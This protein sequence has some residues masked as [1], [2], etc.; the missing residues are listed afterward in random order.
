MYKNSSNV[1]AN[2]TKIYSLSYYLLKLFVIVF[3]RKKVADTRPAVSQIHPMVLPIWVLLQAVTEHHKYPKAIP[4][5]PSCKFF[6][7][8][9]L[10]QLILFLYY[11]I[12]VLKKILWNT[13]DKCNTWC[14][15]ILVITFLEA[16]SIRVRD[17]I[18][19]FLQRCYVA[20]HFLFVIR[21]CLCYLIS[22]F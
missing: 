6:C 12:Y 11:V 18:S 17:V 19:Y 20:Q 8:Y 15:V 16:S 2:C 22:H 13:V 14:H 7:K 4:Q 10:C 5:T 21:C 3:R 9:F 1:T